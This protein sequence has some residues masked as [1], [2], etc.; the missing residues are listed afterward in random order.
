MIAPPWSSLAAAER[1][2]R[3]TRCPAR[4]ALM[5]AAP[6]SLNAGEPALPLACSGHSGPASVPRLASPAGRPLR[7][8]EAD[9]VLGGGASRVAREAVA[10]VPVEPIGLLQSGHVPHPADERQALGGPSDAVRRRRRLGGDHRLRPRSLSLA[11]PARVIRHIRPQGPDRLGASRSG[12]AYNAT[13]CSSPSLARPLEIGPPRMRVLP[14]RDNGREEDRSG[15][16]TARHPRADHP[17]AAR[18][19]A[20]AGRGHRDRRGGQGV[21][22]SE[23]TVPRWRATYG[24]MKADEVKRL[25]ELEAETPASSASSPTRSSR[26]TPCA[27]SRRDG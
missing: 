6:G 23:Q 16:E 15:K 24:G 2:E 4:L 18:G 26:P 12:A 11:V 20:D 9:E 3:P 7:G 14:A 1:A 10:A 22:V 25:K 8:W 19:R 5:A 27:S 13:C 17:Q 21:E